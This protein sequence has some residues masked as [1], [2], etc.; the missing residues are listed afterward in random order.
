MKFI[1]FGEVLFDVIEQK[2]YLGGAPLNLVAHA[3]ALGVDSYLVSS[4]GDD[5][6]GQ[7]ILETLSQV[8]VRKDFVQ[9]DFDHPTGWVDV[10]FDETG[11]HDFTIHTDVAWDYIGYPEGLKQS[12]TENTYDVFCF[13]TLTQR[14]EISRDSLYKILH[15]I[16]AQEKFYDVNLRQDYFSKEIIEKSLGYATIVKFNDEEVDVLENLLFDEGLGAENFSKKMIETYNVKIVIMT[17]GEKGCVI[18]TADEVVKVD[19]VKVNVADTVGAGDAFSAGFLTTYLNTGSVQQA[20]EIGN[21]IGAF[22]AS[23]SG[24]IPTGKV[25]KAFIEKL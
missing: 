2:E 19:G 17:R 20:A 24:A 9:I 6:R 4:V 12:I 14:H 18:V 7:E 16:N 22:V 25:Y 11:N 13:G 5:K 10:F 3:A 21:K 8:G 15:D 1:S 23:Q